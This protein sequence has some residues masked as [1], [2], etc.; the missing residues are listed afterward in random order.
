MAQIIVE[1]EDVAVKPHLQNIA[2][3]ADAATLK[4]LSELIDMPKACEKFKKNAIKL[5][6]AMLLG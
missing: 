4:L 3:K 1:V 6:G 2:K 5:K